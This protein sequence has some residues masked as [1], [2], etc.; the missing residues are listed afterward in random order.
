M[1]EKG[2]GRTNANGTVLGFEQTLWQTA[3]KLRKNIDPPFNS[4]PNYE[5]F[6]GETK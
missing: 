1:T 3:D 2:L 5:A 6:R 4:N